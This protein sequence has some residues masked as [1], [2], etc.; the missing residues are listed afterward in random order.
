MSSLIQHIISYQRHA[1]LQVVER[2]RNHC[3]V[4][5]IVGPFM[6]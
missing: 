3:K 6:F 2:Q 1:S 5:A 4:Q